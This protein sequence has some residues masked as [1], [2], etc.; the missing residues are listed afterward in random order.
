M[1]KRLRHLCRKGEQGLCDSKTFPSWLIKIN[2]H[3][4]SQAQAGKSPTE[5]RG[6]LHTSS[7]RRGWA[8]RGSSKAF[9]HMWVVCAGHL[10]SFFMVR[11]ETFL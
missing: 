10:T 1:S 3:I 8:R 9:L 6:T 5:Y 7:G 4:V 11:V 2:V